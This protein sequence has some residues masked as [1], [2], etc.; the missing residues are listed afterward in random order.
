MDIEHTKD[1][2]RMNEHTS[3]AIIQNFKGN[4]YQIG[5]SIGRTVKGALCDS[6]Y[7]LMGIAGKA[8]AL[9]LPLTKTCPFLWIEKLPEQY[10][11]EVKG[12]ADGSGCSLDLIMQ[13]IFLDRLLDGSCTSFII[14]NNGKAWVGRNNDYIALKM[15]MNINII[16]KDDMIPVMLFGTSGDLF[17][18]TGYNKEKIWLHYNWLPVWDTPKQKAYPAYVFLRMALESCRSIKDVESMLKL[19][20]RDGG[21]N[22]FV[23]DGKNNTFAV[24]ECTCNQY[25]KR[26]APCSY[27]AGANHYCITS[28]PQGYDYDST[29]S[30]IRQKTVEEMLAEMTDTDFTFNDMQNILSCV[31]QN[32]GFHGTVYANISCPAKDKIYYACNDFPAASKGLWEELKWCW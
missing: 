19:I 25:T 23:V 11:I 28:V 16:S 18:G 30:Q 9:D 20:P 4:S 10:Q 14:E 22:L 3:K 26:D 2:R 8:Y 13:W 21:I 15:W 32:K 6:I 1:L 17:S 24:Y 7:E 12:L 29:E 31:E 5:Y 27:I